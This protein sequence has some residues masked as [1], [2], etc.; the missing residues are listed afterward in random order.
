MV[1]P[2]RVEDQIAEKLSAG[3]EHPDVPVVDQDED[4]CAGV[5]ATEADV[6]QPAVV[7]QGEFA[8]AVDL[9]VADPDVAVDQRDP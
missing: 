5:S 8:V 3:A 1:V 7:S 4:G 6:V 9:V 2:G